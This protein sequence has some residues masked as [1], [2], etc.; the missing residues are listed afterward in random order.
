MLSVFTIVCNTL[1][2]SIEIRICTRSGPPL[3]NPYGL[4]QPSPPPTINTDS[5]IRPDTNTQA[6]RIVITIPL[7]PQRPSLTLT[8]RVMTR[9]AIRLND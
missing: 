8:P 6:L 1:E 5:V 9:V 3:S 4:H 2:R 7:P